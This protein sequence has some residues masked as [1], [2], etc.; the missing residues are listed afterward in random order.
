MKQLST[1]IALLAIGT[2][3]LVSSCSKESDSV[4]PENLST[5]AS[6]EAETDNDGLLIFIQ[7]GNGVRKLAGEYDWEMGNN[8]T[9]LPVDIYG[10]TTLM[11]NTKFLVTPSGNR[12]VVCTGVASPAPAAIVYDTDT[13]TDNVAVPSITYTTTCTTQTD[14]KMRFTMTYKQ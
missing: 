4:S 8:L 7:C 5:A 6:A 12:M 10:P 3:L 14:G 11:T 2:T 9:G 13:W 1:S